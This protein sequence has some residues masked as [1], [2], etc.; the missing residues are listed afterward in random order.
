MK[1]IPIFTTAAGVASLVLREIPVW[2]KAY[3]LPRGAFTSA[4]ELAAECAAFCRMAGAKQ[5]S[6]R[7]DSPA[8]GCAFSHEIWE[9]ARPG[10]DLPTPERILPLVPLTAENGEAY[11]ALF[12]R[13]FRAVSGAAHCAADD[14]KALSG[15]WLCEQGG[16]LL[17]LG[18]VTDGELRAIAAAK[19]GVGYD[20]ALA[21]LKTCPSET[22]T[23]RVASDNAPALRLY[24]RLGFEKRAVISRWY[25]VLDPL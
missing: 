8:E 19:P 6:I 25:R 7:L 22:Y 11:R 5:V 17:G 21:L 18:Q 9:L 1:D 3:V 4:A 12:N 23:L 15:A 20:L 16:A 14:L 2:G 10:D 13:R 24:E